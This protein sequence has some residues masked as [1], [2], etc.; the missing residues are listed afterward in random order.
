MEI[1]VIF[2]FYNEEKNILEL[3]NRCRKSLSAF[4]GNYEL[5]FVNDNSKDN[6]LN[7][8][9]K[10][11]EKGD[12]KIINMSRN[13]GVA[14]CVLAG[15][16]YSSGFLVIYM[17]TDLQDPPELIPE[18]IQKWKEN[19]DADVIYTARKS[20]MGENPIKMLVTKL[21]YRLMKS[22]YDVEIPIDAGD[23]K[24]LTRRAVNEV[25]K[26]NE[27]KPFIRGM[28]AYIGFK[29]I[30]VYYD[31]ETRYGGDTHFP[32]FGKK[33][34]FNAL[35][36]ALISY[37]DIPLKISLFVGFFIS[38]LSFLYLIAVIIMKFLGW[39]LPG[40]SAIMATMLILG[41][42][43]L[44]TMGVMG[45]YITN[46]FHQTK[47]RPLYIVKDTYGFNKQE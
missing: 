25:L 22:L 19:P 32:A 8:L 24:L 37:S 28:I 38:A 39:N 23:F 29:Q 5:I 1:S 9:L 12:V 16:Q 20:R 46:I 15:F 36:R 30:P 10:E 3:L 35:E 11:V 34:I 21:G 2:S 13:F 33:V 18:L 40:W 31:R 17:D 14:E 45:L 4:E 27:Q 6:S 43:Q 47:N 42:I 41:G 44:F 7:L 26:M